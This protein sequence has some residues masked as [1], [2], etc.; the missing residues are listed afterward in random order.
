MSW[1]LIID[2]RV[3][4][5]SDVNPAGLY[6]PNWVWH[7]IP[8]TLTGLVTHG[9]SWDATAGFVPPD[10]EL[11]R[12]QRRAALVDALNAAHVALG[13]GV[14]TLEQA[15]WPTQLAEA[16][17]LTASPPDTDG[18]SLPP[19]PLLTLMAAQ[20]GR[21]ETPRNLAERVLAAAAR[22]TAAAG[23]LVAWGQRTEWA[24]AEAGTAEALMAVDV[25]PPRS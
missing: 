21:D 17:A 4:Q 18:D 22:Y 5:T 3:R 16:L 23:A 11:L 2:G 9:W 12:Q 14:S 15:T 7:A 8:D 6:P 20:R 1:A 19:C 24:L 10:I 13:A 25:T